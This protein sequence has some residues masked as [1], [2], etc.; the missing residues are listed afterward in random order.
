MSTP[1]TEPVRPGSGQMFDQ[2]AGRYDLLNRI[3]SLGVDQGWRKQTVRSLELQ[4]ACRV[5]DVA[6]GTGD[7]AIAIARMLP[8]AEVVGVDPS[9]GMLKVGEEKL[10]DAALADR[11]SLRE[12][13]V[14]ALP[15]E[16]DSFDAVTIAFGIRNAQ[17]RAKGLAEM[18]RV[19]RSGGRVAVLEL[20]EP[21][22]GL[23]R[24][25]ARFHIRTVVPFV[26]GFLSGSRE[27][28]YLQTSI[29]AF[30]PRAEFA[31][32]MRTAGLESVEARPLTFGA[33]NLFVGVAP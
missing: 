20:G 21:E 15:C 25:L 6:T 18:A 17:D 28:R 22:E 7:L 9:V 29:A 10:R 31:E 27:Y 30:P 2:I 12:G 19:T 11:V 3:L 23:L 32:M 5:L 4:G 14:E 16:D 1:P 26:G 33:A 24:S 8:E 13:S